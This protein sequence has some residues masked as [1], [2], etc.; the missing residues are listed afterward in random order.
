MSETT[1]QPSS[2]EMPTDAKNSQD[3][4]AA[5]KTDDRT[6]HDERELGRISDIALMRRLWRWMRPYKLTFLA[7]LLLLPAAY[8]MSLLQPHLVQLAV[9]RHL[10]PQHLAGLEVYAFA[11]LASVVCEYGLRFGQMYL[12]QLAGQRALRDLRCAAFDRLQQLD[13]AFFHRNPVGRVMSRLTTDVDA[14]NEALSSGVVTIIGDLTMLAAI[15]VILLL[16]N[17]QLALITFITVPVL[18]GLTA[19][20]RILMRKA[21]RVSRVK[22]ARLNANLQEAVTGM[23]IIQL[24]RHE[25]AS[26]REYEE[27]NRDYRGAAF[28]MIR[29]DAMLYAIVEMISSI[30]IALII[31]YGAGQAIN[32]LVTLG[33]LVAFI[34]YVE[35]FFVPIRDLSQKYT[36][37]QSAMAA[38]ERIFQLLDEEVTVLEDDDALPIARLERGIEFR[39]VWFAYTDDNWVLRDVSFSIKRG[40]SL[41][42]VGHTGAGKSTITALLSRFY[43]VQQGHIL[44]DGVDIRRYRVDDLRALFSVVLQDGFLFTGSLGDNVTLGVDGVSSADVDHAASI[45]GLD[46]LVQRFNG[47]YDH[48]ILERGGNVSTGERQLITFARALAR[49]P[50]VLVL[51]EA[52]ANVDTET[53]AWIQSAIERML[54][55]QT[56]IVVAHRLSTIQRVDRIVVLH[57]GE[58]AQIGS[59][60]EL[61]AV[62]GIYRTLVRLQYESMQGG[63]TVG[64]PA[65]ALPQAPQGN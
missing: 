65:G 45:V 50:D 40:E 60:D 14:L 52:T 11:F 47:G 49:R 57:H 51:D 53:E 3:T 9:D 33:V 21:Y 61:V 10:V 4:S 6:M 15:V 19:L 20:F 56:S 62:D 23:S 22:I 38:S 1:P 17:W 31:W 42:L 18:V 13:L 30:T 48:P 35:K 16:K 46:R 58:V 43:D 24:F 55:H 29:W 37:V 7:C 25:Q 26:F 27:I 36:M 59:H 39:N 54:S 41:A 8:G 12:M 44:V 63:G 32:D 28:S 2:D 5:K 64:A 34:Q